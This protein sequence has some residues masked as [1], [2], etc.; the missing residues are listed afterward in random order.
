[1]KLTLGQDVSPVQEARMAPKSLLLMRHA[2]KPGDLSHPH[3]SPAAR[4]GPSAW[5]H[6]FRSSLFD[7]A[8]TFDFSPDGLRVSELKENF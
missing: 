8:L 3:L 7:P 6:G 2:D 5:R 1:V 4:R